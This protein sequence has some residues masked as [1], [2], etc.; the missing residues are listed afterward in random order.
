MKDMKARGFIYKVSILLILTGMFFVLC[1]FNN[2]DNGGEVRKDNG[3]TIFLVGDSRTVTGYQDTHDPRVNWLGTCGS[4][5]N[6]FRENY[7]PLIS[8]EP[9]AGKKIVI[10]YG[11]NDATRYGAVQATS[12]WINF[13]NTTA[14]V[15]INRGATVIVGT[16]PPVGEDLATLAIGADIDAMNKTIAEY[17]ALIISQLPSNIKPIYIGY[18]TKKPLRDGVH[19]SYEEDLVLYPDLITRLQLM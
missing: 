17:N 4:D 12:N 9:L 13:Y 15:W 5:Y 18:S 2:I 10:L 1:G 7:L 19:Y 14:Q 3:S 8:A 6:Y 11:V 16:V